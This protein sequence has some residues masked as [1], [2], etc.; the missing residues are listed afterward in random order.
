M[1]AFQRF[2]CPSFFHPSTNRRI[3]RLLSSGLI[4]P[5]T[6]KVISSLKEQL[7]DGKPGTLCLIFVLS[8]NIFMAHDAFDQSGKSSATECCSWF[9]P[10]SSCAA[11]SSAA[12]VTPVRF[13]RAP[14]LSLPGR[15]L[16]ARSTCRSSRGH[17]ADHVEASAAYGGT[18][19]EV[20]EKQRTDYWSNRD[21]RVACVSPHS[22]KA[23]LSRVK[24]AA[25]FKSTF[26]IRLIACSSRSSRR[27]TI[28]WCPVASAPSACA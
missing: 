9:A 12:V 7:R 2:S 5:L 26:P 10:A 22:K 17:S 18:P 23:W 11:R 1:Y 13:V 25:H 4:T 3:Y 14:S 27:P 28:F 19:P 6:Q 20:R 21:R 16:P 24:K 8:G 15:S